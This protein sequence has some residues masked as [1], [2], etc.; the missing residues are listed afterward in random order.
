MPNKYSELI[1]KLAF[2]NDDSGSFEKCVKIGKSIHGLNVHIQYGTFKNPGPLNTGENGMHVHDFDQLMLCIG[3]DPNNLME[4]GAEVEVCLGKEKERHLFAAPM[5]IAIPKGVPH[6]PATIKK[7][8][9]KF[10]YMEISLAPEFQAAAVPSEPEL[11]QP[12]LASNFQ[13]RYR[14]YVKPLQFMRK[15][16]Y[17]YGSNN[18]EDSGGVIT[19]LSG[20]DSGLS[21]HVSY[22]SIMNTPYTFGP[23]PHRPHVHKFEE[24]LLFMS[25]DCNNLNELPVEAE[26]SLGKEREINKISGYYCGCLPEMLPHCPLT[27]TRVDKPFIFMVVSCAAEHHPLPKIID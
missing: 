16:P 25:P 26:C 21:L 20:H 3:S 18:P 15:A 11:P 14:A 10:Q 13:A 22:E 23:A 5:A 12:P 19:T 8:D 17:F 1:K 4:L 7:M 24:I 2:K 6:F 27:I 9:K